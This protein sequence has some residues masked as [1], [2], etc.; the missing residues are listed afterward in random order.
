MVNNAAICL[1]LALIA[2]IVGRTF[3]RPSITHLI[4]LLVLVKL[5]TPPVVTISAFPVPWMMAANSPAAFETD[6]RTVRQDMGNAFLPGSLEREKDFLEDGFGAAIHWKQLL[7]LAW[8][9]GSGIVFVW[10][11][12]QVYRFHRLFKK[13]SRSGNPEICEMA[14]E[15]ASY[16]GLRKIPEIRTVSARVSPMVWWIGGKVHIV[17][18]D[19]LLERMEAQEL[20]WILA[21]ELAHVRRRDFYIR[22]VEWLTCVLFWWYPVA[23]W[24][25]RN[26]RINEELCCDELVL[27]CLKPQPFTYGE[28]LLKTVEI[29]SGSKNC[30]P[31][32]ASGITS[33]ELLKRRVQILLS[34]KWKAPRLR[35]VQAFILPGALIVLP[36]G[37]TSAQTRNKDMAQIPQAEDSS[38]FPSAIPD[39]MRAVSIRV[40]N[41]LGRFLSPGMRV[42]VI[43]TDTLPEGSERI[44]SRVIFRNIQVLAAGENVKQNSEDRSQKVSVVTLLVTPEQARELALAGSGRIQLLLRNPLDEEG[45]TELGAK[46]AIPKKRTG[47]PLPS[48]IPDGMR[49]ISIRVDSIIGADYVSPGM[50]VDIIRKDLSPNG[51]KLDDSRIIL[52]NIQVLTAGENVE[53]NSEGRPQKVSVVV[54]LVTPEQAQKLV[55]EGPSCIQLEVRN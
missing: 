34:N 14:A 12:S 2:L 16:M 33:G 40:D 24:A 37:L 52:E 29:L 9:L 1:I 35:W 43:R 19:V 7:F 15:T 13:E 46:L 5:L 47:L 4:W 44:G 22:W 17:I 31:I 6:L 23:W 49:A 38:N 27:S 25:R 51:S 18:P 21:H 3:R 11:L 42:D 32:L 26:L 30:K 53:Q 54:L 28:S 20:R 41:K 10:S 36:L 45:G 48:L 55:L 50:R 8:S 39:G